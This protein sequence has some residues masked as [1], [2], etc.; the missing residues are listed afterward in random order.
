MTLSTA[1]RYGAEFDAASNASLT[2]GLV[3]DAGNDI[4]QS[5]AIP[6]DVLP[7]N[8]WREQG[9]A[10]GWIAIEIFVQEAD[11]DTCD[12][13]LSAAETENMSGSVSIMSVHF[14]PAQGTGYHLRAAITVET[15]R[16]LFPS[17]RFIG[18]ST[19]KSGG[20]TPQ[21]T[22]SAHLSHLKAA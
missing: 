7:A 13:I 10:G 19:D 22:Y 9:L 14:A 1:S 12:F 21:I 5:T 4:D 8:A 2:D 18:L 20:G 3:T 17:A 11:L 6:L 16:Q 15:I